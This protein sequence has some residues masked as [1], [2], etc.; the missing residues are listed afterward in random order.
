MRGEAGD[1]S[2]LLIDAYINA[3]VDPVQWLDGL[4]KVLPI[5][6]VT[7]GSGVYYRRVFYDAGDERVIGRFNADNREA[8]RTSAIRVQRGNLAN[9]FSLHYS[10]NQAFYRNRRVISAY[11]EE[12]PI[13][14]GSDTRIIGDERCRLSQLLYGVIERP[15]IEFPY[16]WSESTALQCLRHLSAR[17]ALPRRSVTYDVR[18]AEYLR[19]GDIIAITDTEAHLTNQRAMVESVTIGGQS[20]RLSLSLL[21]TPSKETG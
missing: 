6:R 2:R 9:L 21:D 3:P 7:T 5:R 13:G 18:G 16:T 10:L 4:G 8:T 12:W 19:S 17:D 14:T 1:L 11:A 20:A 15:P